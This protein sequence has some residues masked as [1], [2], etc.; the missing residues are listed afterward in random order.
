MSQTPHYHPYL[1]PAD[2]IPGHFAEDASHLSFGLEGNAAAV[3]VQ[4][5]QLPE[6]TFEPLAMPQADASMQPFGAASFD[7]Q[8][9]GSGDSTDSDAGDDHDTAAHYHNQPTTPGT[10]PHLALEY[11]THDHDNEKQFH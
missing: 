9:Q 11:D 6:Q 8:R 1:Q 3:N 7:M 5:F 2:N 10:P 4:P